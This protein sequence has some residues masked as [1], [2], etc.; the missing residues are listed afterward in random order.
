MP[1]SSAQTTSTVAARPLTLKQRLVV[2][3]PVCCFL[4]PILIGVV[5]LNVEALH[6]E[7]TPAVGRLVLLASLLSVPLALFLLMFRVSKVSD[8]LKRGGYI[9][10]ICAFLTGVVNQNNWREDTA[11]MMVVFAV[12]CFGLS[13][14][15]R[16]VARRKPSTAPSPS[17]K[18]CPFCAETVKRDAVLCRFC[19]RTFAEERHV[20]GAER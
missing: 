4:C 20:V 6:L 9:A 1:K 17:T 10:L 11:S 19:G 3:A 2:A 13:Y 14:V 7:M 18:K 8:L 15:V 16:F 5:T 12:V